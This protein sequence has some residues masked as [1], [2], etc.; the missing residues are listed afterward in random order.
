ML[1]P[2]TSH[3]DTFARDRLPP[4]EQW[5]TLLLDRPEVRYPAKLNCAVELVDVMAGKTP[6]APCFRSPSE[7][8]TYREFSERVNRFAHVLV[9][10]LGLVPGGRVLLRAANNPDMMALW[11]A[12][13]KAGGIVVATMPLLRAGELQKVLDRAK[14]GIALCD[15]RL[16]EELETA[17]GRV[18]HDVKVM[19]FHGA[20]E[21]DELERRAAT[22]PA[23]F[24]AVDTAADDVV[25]I[26]FT[27]GTTGNPK[28]TMHFHRDILAICDTYS[29]SIVRPK[30]S[31]VFIGSPPIAFTFGLGGLV[32]F[33]MRVGASSILLEAAAPDLLRDAIGAYGATT[34]FTSP[35]AYRRM[36][37]TPAGDAFA[38]LRKC[39]SAGETLPLP[40][41]Q[42]WERET[43]IRIMDGIGA[44]E[45]LHIFIG[46][47]VEA[48][49]PG[50]TGLP[51]PGYE[52]RIVGEDLQP[53]EPG[54]IGRLAV[55]GPTGCRYLDDPRQMDYVKNGWNMT[56]DTFEMDAD[57]YF[58][59]RARNDDMIVT[60]GYNVGGPEVEDALLE[61]AAVAECAVVGVPDEERGQVIKAV[62]VLRP[63][64][65]RNDDM[66]RG[67]QDHVKATIAPYKYPRV[68]EF[69]DALPRTETGKVQRYV[70]RGEKR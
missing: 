65:E 10:D 50:A 28:G 1:G 53:V 22:K 68:V 55:R 25:L 43:G 7:S 32:L 20:G 18:D 17:V 38:T 57:G 35:T 41:F 62:V 37:A 2:Y 13:A 59:Y 27:S 12:V 21:E 70:L 40:V 52:A 31:E 15:V 30:A 34:L 64:F 36:L 26:A 16:R 42:A 45:M 29:A 56:G 67:L 60:S 4:V 49:R 51:V 63:G 44:T 66:V 58:H 33:P 3:V 6:D 54:Q 11:F 69:V 47:P 9:E 61:H 19:T 23:A 46:A 39:V 24:D 8:L 5:P 48:I 14:V